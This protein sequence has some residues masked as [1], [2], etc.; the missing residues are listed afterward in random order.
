MLRASTAARRLSRAEIKR[1]ERCRFFIIHQVLLRC[2]IGITVR[3]KLPCLRR[4]RSWPRNHVVLFRFVCSR[5]TRS[6]DLCN[7]AQYSASVSKKIRL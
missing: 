4:Y 2:G 1:N 6:I 3:Y 5:F 7:L